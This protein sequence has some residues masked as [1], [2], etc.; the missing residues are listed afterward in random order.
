MWSQR[1]P[2]YGGS[3]VL[4]ILHE[5]TFHRET[6]TGQAVVVKGGGM[7]RN[8]IIKSCDFTTLLSFQDSQEKEKGT[9]FKRC[10]LGT[11]KRP[12]NDPASE[13]S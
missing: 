12:A 7:G 1:C 11:L 5:R 8:L 13:P 4:Q 2:Y 3:T 9:P 6:F 10:R